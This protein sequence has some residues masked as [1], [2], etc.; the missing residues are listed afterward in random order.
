MAVHADAEDDQTSPLSVSICEGYM[1]TE[2][3]KGLSHNDLNIGFLQD[4]Q[5]ITKNHYITENHYITQP[6]NTVV[7][8]SITKSNSLAYIIQGSSHLGNTVL[9]VL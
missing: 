1:D 6:G 9:T 5:S 4:R 2:Q 8:G 7:L 3:R